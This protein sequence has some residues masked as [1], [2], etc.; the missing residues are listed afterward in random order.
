MS[1]CVFPEIVVSRQL[2]TLIVWP[3]QLLRKSLTP[4]HVPFTPDCGPPHSE[5]PS[6][7]SDCV[8]AGHLPPLDWHGPCRKS[9]Q[10][11][12]AWRKGYLTHILFPL[13]KH[14]P[15]S[16][17]RLDHCNLEARLD[18]SYSHLGS[19]WGLLL[20]MEDAEVPGSQARW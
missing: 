18:S 10:R 14:W 16:L 15:T 3:T 8:P 7:G 2:R 20:P 11:V 4:L 19:C 17:H 12:Y 1:T 6:T 5:Q 9:R 13:S